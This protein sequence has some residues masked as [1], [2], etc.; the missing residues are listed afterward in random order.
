MSNIPTKSGGVKKAILII[1][2]AILLF[3][4]FC[5]GCLFTLDKLIKLSEPAEGSKC[6]DSLP[7][8]NELKCI[9][10]TCSSGKKGSYCE[11]KTDCSTPYCVENV[12]REDIKVGIYVDEEPKNPNNLKK[13]KIAVITVGMTDGNLTVDNI[14]DGF[15]ADIDRLNKALTEMKKRPTLTLVGE[16]ERTINGQRV[17]AM[18]AWEVKKNE[19]N[20]AYAVV[21]ALE[22]EFGL[23]AEVER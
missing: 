13:I 23:R 1:L 20:Y 11:S 21:H 22:M 12:C 9:G 8:K 14:K 18:E 10:T 4:I 19:P 17:I 6:S 5:A 2:G 3:I 15:S 16:N 7:C